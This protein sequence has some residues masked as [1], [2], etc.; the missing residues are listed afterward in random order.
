MVLWILNVLQHWNLFKTKVLQLREEELPSLL[1][2]H[3]CEK[4]NVLPLL[5]YT[6]HCL[7]ENP[8]MLR[9]A[10]HMEDESFFFFFTM[11]EFNLIGQLPLVCLKFITCIHCL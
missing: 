5:T 4:L 11:S 8:C 7:C 3:H 6:L 1:T 10:V 2:D 9:C